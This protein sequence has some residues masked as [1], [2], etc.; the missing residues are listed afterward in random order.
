MV[1]P[2][3][4]HPV[5]VVLEKVSRSTTIQDPDY[6]EPVQLV[7]RTAQYT[8]SAQVKWGIDKKMDTDS[9][10]LYE[11]SD[12]YL[13]LSMAELRAEG[14]SDIEEGDRFIRIGTGLN[15]RNVDLYVTGIRPIAHYP[16]QSGA[17]LVKAFF[18]DKQ[19]AHQNRG[20]L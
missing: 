16:D 15:A 1:L 2:R 7:D 19:P 12:G 9:S 18:A 5:T 8:L 3:L 14:L 4:L 13:L 20:G 10:G 17:A 6:E 11:R